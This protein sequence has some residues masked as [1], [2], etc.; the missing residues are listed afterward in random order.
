MPL[1]RREFRLL[2][3][4]RQGSEDIVP[5]LIFDDGRFTYLRFAN[6]REVPAVF[7]VLGDGSSRW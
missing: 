1:P 6:N 5:S 2:D 4:R 3:R 7:H